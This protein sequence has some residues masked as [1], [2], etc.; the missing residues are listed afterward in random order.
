MDMDLLFPKAESKPITVREAFVRIENKPSQV[1]ISQKVIDKWIRAKQGESLWNYGA[2]QVKVNPDNPSPAFTKAGESA[3]SMFHYE[4]PRPLLVDE[5]K[6]IQ[7]FP[8][9]FIFRGG[10]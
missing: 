7:T 8:D 1:D 2:G 4:Y 9:D 6:R 10:V 3:Y 5:M